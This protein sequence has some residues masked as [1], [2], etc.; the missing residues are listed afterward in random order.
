MSIIPGDLYYTKHD[1]WIRVNGTEGTIGITDYAQDSL[2]DIVFVELPDE[3][4]IFDRDENFGSI[5]SVKAVADLFTPV[6]GEILEVNETLVDAPEII[7]SDPYGQG[8]IMKIK[9][10]S[11]D[12][13]DTLMDAGAYEAYEKERE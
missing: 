11:S 12:E 10:S 13:L 7:N 5:E 1:E 6:G 9:I 2:G 3:G 8:W 4:A